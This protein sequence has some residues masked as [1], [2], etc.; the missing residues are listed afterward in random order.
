MANRF[1][2]GYFTDWN[3]MMATLQEGSK[4]AFKKACQRICDE[5]NERIRGGI[6]T[7]GDIQGTYERTMEMAN[8]DYLMAD[9]QG[10]ECQFRYDNQ[11]FMSL[12]ID[13]PEHHGLSD[14]GAN[15]NY[16][17]TAFM[18]KI[19]SPIHDDFM[20][21]IRDYIQKNFANIYRQCCKE[22]GFELK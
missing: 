12:S 2:K 11:E 3:E 16:D 5:C 10:L 14:D 21:D 1:G 8:M 4:R 9:I 19:I 18:E 15:A 7:L 17:T 22:E 20:S 6:Y 13:N